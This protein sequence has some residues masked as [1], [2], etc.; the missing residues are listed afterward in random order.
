MMLKFIY[1]EEATKV[2]E[3]FTLILSHVVPVKSKVKILQNFV[4]FSGYMN[5]ISALWMVSSKFRKRLHGNK[6]TELLIHNSFFLS[7]PR[8]K[9][10]KYSSVLFFCFQSISFDNLGLDKKK[11]L[12]DDQ[13]S[14][15]VY[16]HSIYYA[17][18]CTY[19]L[20]YIVT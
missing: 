15:F 19:P 13:F 18:N 6:I 16:I 17:H 2:C 4:A 11:L 1:S 9:V 8:T 14:S 3:I 20:T 10:Y 12:L 5:F 7:M